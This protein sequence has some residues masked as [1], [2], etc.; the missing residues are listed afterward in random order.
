[1]AERENLVE[2]NSRSEKVVAS[3]KRWVF[4]AVGIGLAMGA[5]VWANESTL[6]TTH[7]LNSILAAI[8]VFIVFGTE[9]ILVREATAPLNLMTVLINVAALLFP[10]MNIAAY[11]RPLALIFTALCILIAWFAI[12][13]R[14]VIFFRER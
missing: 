6:R 2:H 14:R 5:M 12:R 10:L 7:I 1:M 9:I 11:S 3:L 4:R 13:K 8:V